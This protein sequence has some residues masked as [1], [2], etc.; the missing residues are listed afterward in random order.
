VGGV[1]CGRDAFDLLDAGATAVQVGTALF[2]DPRSIARVR[3]ELAE[4]A[5]ARQ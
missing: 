2:R 4:L 3:A 5:G 1:V